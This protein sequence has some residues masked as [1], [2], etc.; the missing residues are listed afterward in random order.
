MNECWCCWGTGRVLAPSVEVTCRR[1]LGETRGTQVA[2][3]FG[4]GYQ[5]EPSLPILSFTSIAQQ[6]PWSVR[7]AITVYP[8]FQDAYFSHVSLFLKSEWIIKLKGTFFLFLPKCWPWHTLDGIFEIKEWGISV[9][10]SALQLDWNLLL[11]RGCLT[12]PFFPVLST[13]PQTHSLKR[14]SSLHFPVFCAD[15]PKLPFTW[16]LD[17]YTAQDKNQCSLSQVG[18]SSVFF[19]VPVLPLPQCV[20]VVIWLLYY[21]LL[22]V[23][24]SEYTV[25]TSFLTL[26]IRNICLKLLQEGCVISAC[27]LFELFYRM[28][29]KRKVV[30]LISPVIQCILTWNVLEM[31][32]V[33]QPRCKFH[34]DR[35]LLTALS[36]ASWKSALNIVSTQIIMKYW[37]L[38]FIW[39]QFLQ[40]SQSVSISSCDCGV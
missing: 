8:W 36:S 17:L 12:W 33:N 38:S 7:V 10:V 11:G 13:V 16:F 39:T 23:K 40:V 4:A 9:Y 27:K 19:T 32:G 26:V 34:E 5:E 24:M 18:T 6:H 31:G 14:L 22:T 35:V 30:W 21:I 15:A 2:E 28:A 20:W 29:Q 1:F 25:Q 37:L 3:F